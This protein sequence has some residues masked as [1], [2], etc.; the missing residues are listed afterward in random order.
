MIKL[1]QY[2]KLSRQSGENAV[3]W[4]QRLRIKAVEC[5]YKE[6][7]RQLKNSSFME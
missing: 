4:M 3:E 1:L 6:L 2:C 7:D 5:N